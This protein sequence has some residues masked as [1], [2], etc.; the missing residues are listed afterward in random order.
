M[1][2]YI[3][4]TYLSISVHIKSQAE[5]PSLRCGAL[6]KKTLFFFSLIWF[7]KHWKRQSGTISKA[8]A[9]LVRTSPDPADRAVERRIISTIIKKSVFHASPASTSAAAQ[10][11]EVQR[12][13][14]DV[15]QAWEIT[16]K[17]SSPPSLSAVTPGFSWSSS[18]R[19]RTHYLV[20]INW[21]WS[22][23]V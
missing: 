9:A 7:Y 8:G 10:S 18:S 19:T 11:C 15:N 17:I 22:D 5:K 23:T 3:V 2:F 1:I 16:Q 21:L 4:S 6:K 13:V 20:V 14:S 12:G